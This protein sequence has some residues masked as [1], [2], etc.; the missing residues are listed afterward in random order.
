MTYVTEA[1]GQVSWS[2]KFEWRHDLAIGPTSYRIS[3]KIL[4]EPQA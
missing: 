3:D 4:L 2:N 1:A